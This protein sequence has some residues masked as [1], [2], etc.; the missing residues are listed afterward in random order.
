VGPFGDIPS[1]LAGW[2]LR[3]LKSIWMTSVNEGA[4]FLLGYAVLI[5]AAIVEAYF[6]VTLRSADELR[7]DNF[8]QSDHQVQDE[9]RFVSALSVVLSA[10]RPEQRISPGTCP[11]N[12]SECLRARSVINTTVEMADLIT[13]HE[14]P[15]TP[16]PHK[17]GAAAPNPAKS[18]DV[19]SVANILDENHLPAGAAATAKMAVQR[20]I[21]IL[22]QFDRT[23]PNSAILLPSR[24]KINASIWIVAS[25]SDHSALQLTRCNPAVAPPGVADEDNRRRLEFGLLEALCEE[26]E[27]DSS[28]LQLP[29]QIAGLQSPATSPAHAQLFDR[30]NRAIGISYALEAALRASLM[31]VTTATTC[32]NGQ[33]HPQC[34]QDA[35]SE[36]RNFSAAYFVSVDSVMRY[37]R[38]ET[39]EP[40][41]RLPKDFHWAQREYFRA[42]ETGATPLTEE[43]VSQPYIDTSGIGIV[44]TIC[45]AVTAP[46]PD[47]QDLLHGHRLPPI[48]DR[49]RRI[50]GVVCADLALRPHAVRSLVSYIQGG[51]LV[52]AGLVSIQGDG[53]TTIDTEDGVTE[54]PYLN[55]LIES[56]SWANI[57]SP[58]W[59][60]RAPGR[61][62][63]KFKD[64]SR[65][66]YVVPIAR[67]GTGLLAI[68]LRP[69]PSSAV[70]RLFRW[71]LFGAT[72]GAVFILLTVTANR[73]RRVA[74]GVRDLA[75]LRGLGV[76]V[77]EIRN[78]PEAEDYAGHIIMAGNDRAEEILQVALP[79][80]GLKEGAHPAMHTL[81]DVDS[82]IPADADGV[83]PQWE[84]MSIR[85]MLQARKRG[86][87]STYF[88]PLKRPRSIWRFPSQGV[89]EQRL[90]YT[91]MRIVAGPLV[92]PFWQGTTTQHARGRL[93]SVVAVLQPVFY[94]PLAKLLDYIRSVTASDKPT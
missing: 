32:I 65:V 7:L 3:R 27:S 12:S 11:S 66:W 43:Y 80:F 35:D 77:I 34:N 57:F 54:P 46:M 87:V 92:L 36:S 60:S 68:A 93:E 8:L 39:I 38:D 74:E 79:N 89:R 70:G 86:D 94:P 45:R 4:G 41:E 90:E 2:Y 52:S 50:A 48:A 53:D 26:E 71:L 82:L 22:D 9:D 10:F 88:A 75:R 78:P 67:S 62:P 84:R 40:V 17:P 56:Q 6:C 37:W 30:L 58:G 1:E 42:F 83:T 69:S 51:A 15:N 73:S 5:L 49:Q 28:G 91:W 72:C 61:A 33:V 64:N 20:G 19:E 14:A 18:T 13:A 25:F 47:P 63:T 59:T 76:A 44:Q 81:F 24:A 16:S 31:Q 55:E 85:K 29:E 21:T 23:E